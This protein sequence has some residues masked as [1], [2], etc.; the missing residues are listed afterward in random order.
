[1]THGVLVPGASGVIPGA[2]LLAPGPSRPASRAS[3]R[4]DTPVSEAD[5]GAAGTRTP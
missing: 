5:G 3:I 4:R 2:G 1:M